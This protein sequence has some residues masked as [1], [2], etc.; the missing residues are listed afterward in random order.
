MNDRILEDDLEIFDFEWY[1]IDQIG[2]IARFFSGG[3]LMPAGAMKSKSDLK[4]L[5]N[6]FNSL[7]DISEVKIFHPEINKFI[8]R[9]AWSLDNIGLH[10]PASTSPGFLNAYVPM[11]KKG[12]YSYCSKGMDDFRD[13]YFCVTQPLSS[14][15]SKLKSIDSILLNGTK[16][17]Q[18]TQD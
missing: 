13:E 18:S 4:I 6:Y 16:R 15:N 2:Q 9:A 1:G 12:V 5:S 8:G 10:V 17:N 14:V 11:S 3:F 7:P